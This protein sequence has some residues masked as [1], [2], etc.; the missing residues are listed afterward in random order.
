[1]GI[2]TIEPQVARG[3]PHFFYY[4]FFWVDVG[5]FLPPTCLLSSVP[6]HL[7]LLS[8]IFVPLN[9]LRD[10]PNQNQSY[11]TMTLLYVYLLDFLIMF[12]DTLKKNI[13]IIEDFWVAF[14]LFRLSSFFPQMQDQISCCVGKNISKHYF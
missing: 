12:G 4:Y 2:L 10:G 8:G 14:S 1:M 6:L 13:R 11:L 3:I 5:H 7:S 9:E